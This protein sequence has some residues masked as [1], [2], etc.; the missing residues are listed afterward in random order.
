MT[1]KSSVETEARRETSDEGWRQPSADHDNVDGAQH[2]RSVSRF[3][4]GALAKGGNTVLQRLTCGVFLI[5][6]ACGGPFNEETVEGMRKLTGHFRSTKDGIVDFKLKV[7][8]EE[9]AFLM[10]V[11]TD[12]PNYGY[13]D[14]LQGPKKAELLDAAEEWNSPKM[15]TS[16]PF[17][18]D[19]MTLNWPITGE[20]E[21]EKGKFHIDV[22]IVDH[23]DS[24]VK[25]GPCKIE[26]LL[27]EDSDLEEGTLKATIFYAGS[28]DGDANIATATQA[29]VERWR[30]L[31]EPAG[32]EVEVEYD[33][34]D[35]DRFDPPGMGTEE[36]Y[37]NLSASTTDRTVNIII[38]PSIQLWD[39]I[40]GIAGD[41]PGPLV[42]SSRSAV[43]LSV[44]VSAGPDGYF[45][46]MEERLFGET[47]AHETAHFLGLFHPVETTWD[48]WDALEDTPG[49]TTE[50][51]CLIEM[52]DHLMFPFPLCGPQTCEP[53][54]V[55][56]DSQIEVLNRYV[57]VD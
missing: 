13:T 30:T 46:A 10:T 51:E 21:F 19:V 50:S 29:A 57:G 42:S 37:E 11:T 16:A 24:M 52:G 26:I 2:P 4:I 39:E 43:L 35:E 32:I 6:G 44:E 41:I 25:R 23:S 5:L 56:T 34:W 55:I 40:Y 36:Q 53:Q 8:K 49:C 14:Y 1:K 48:T 22:G 27:K 45:N 54:T 9:T 47:I 31:Y 12:A 17:P 15:R 38:A 7:D 33:S 28:V 18:A 3:V 20:D